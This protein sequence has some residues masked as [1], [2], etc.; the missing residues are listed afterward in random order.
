MCVQ[1]ERA[2]KNELACGREVGIQARFEGRG[3]WVATPLAPLHCGTR[4]SVQ[5]LFHLTFHSEA[6]LA[7]EKKRALTWDIA[8]RILF[9]PSSCFH[10]RN[11]HKPHMD[12][13][14][15]KNCERQVR[16]TFCVL[17]GWTRK[18]LQVT[19]RADDSK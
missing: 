8:A 14:Q 16:E 1:R 15:T 12:I 18:N 6:L 19:A 13:P 4:L 17:G 11:D 2:G 3:G 7:H 9:P 10:T 5:F